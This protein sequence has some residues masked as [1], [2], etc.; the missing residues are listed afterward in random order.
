MSNT[1]KML[2]EL[3]SAEGH[4]FDVG[5]NRA[6]LILP[7]KRAS[8]EPTPWI[9]YAPTFI[10]NHP[11]L[12][13]AWM[14]EQLLEEGIALA[15][16]EIG[17]SFGNPEGRSVFTSVYEML[18]AERGM[19]SHPCLMP[20]SRGGLMLY[21]W[22]A[23]HPL[24]VSCIAGIFTV[25]D[26]RSYPGLDK[27]CAAYGMSEDELAGCLGEHN[28]VDRLGPLAEADVPIFHVHGDS[29]VVVPL[30]ENSGAMAQRYAELGGRMSLKVIPGKG[31]EVISEFF[32][33]PELV[34]FVIRNIG[35]S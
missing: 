18:V 28:P 7:E 34:E 2:V 22:A 11:N 17:E 20:Q 14:F 31:H 3:L 24:C 6:F 5:D 13:H 9:W 8:S 32:E 10:E 12:S 15:G 26:L 23:E 25:C 33:C 21:N 27:A 29:D 30:K 35:G 1:V 4:F 16:V 19:S